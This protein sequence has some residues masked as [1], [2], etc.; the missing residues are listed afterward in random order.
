MAT[1][2]GKI[3]TI[4][5]R[6]QYPNDTIAGSLQRKGLSR[7]PKT[8]RKMGPAKNKDGSYRNGLDVK[9]SYLDRLS[10]EQKEQEIAK[11]NGLAELANMYYPNLDV[12]NPR[13]P[14]WAD[15]AKKHGRPDVAPFA[16][17]KDGDNIFD[18]SVPE[19]L[20]VYAYLRVHPYIA[21]SGTSVLQGEYS[22]AT[23]YVND[24][25]VETAIAYKVKSQI[26]KALVKLEKLNPTKRKMVARQL[27][28]SVSDNSSEEA[29]YV[30]LTD[31]INE[32]T[33]PKKS[34]NVNL[35]ESF[36]TMG[37]EDLKI[38]D[39]IKQS[40]THS[41]YRRFKSAIYRGDVRVASKE[42]ELVEY[43]T[44]PQN[45]DELIAIKEELK[46]KKSIKDI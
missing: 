20:I 28:I 16:E 17:L 34:N 10:P 41:I 37:D 25:D 42:D 13:S 31:F 3:S 24:F 18:L 32:S 11:I 33:S 21:P 27:G 43:L 12:T 44:N 39:I 15:M 2:I 4:K 30:L 36:A 1:S 46:M 23:Y 26:T 38:R 22:Q 40:L 14:F 29:V 7:A 35:F 19:E 45:Q 9:A 5:R 6:D 8:L